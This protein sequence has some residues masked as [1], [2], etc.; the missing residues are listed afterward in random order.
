MSPAAVIYDALVNALD[1]QASVK[2]MDDKELVQVRGALGRGEF[3]AWTAE[4]I[5][6][7]VML[8]MVER[9]VE[10]VSHEATKQEPVIHII[11]T[12]DDSG[13]EAV[14]DR[15]R[16]DIAVPLKNPSGCDRGHRSEV[17]Q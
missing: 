9:F 7:M 15:L 6:G 4:R 3:P 5:H 10:K 13:I 1:L 16:P 2:L 8:E 17:P 12:A 14:M 11:I